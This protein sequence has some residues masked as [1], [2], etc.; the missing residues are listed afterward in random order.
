L[1]SYGIFAVNMADI[2][3]VGIKTR[4]DIIDTLMTGDPTMGE[5]NTGLDHT[6]QP[7]YL[8]TKPATGT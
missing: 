6:A 4:R 7:G 1:A 2:D 8:R 3:A 5:R